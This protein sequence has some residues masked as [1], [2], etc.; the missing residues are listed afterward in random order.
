ME[1]CN[2]QYL[3]KVIKMRWRKGKSFFLLLNK[4]NQI[5]QFRVIFYKNLCNI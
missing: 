3:I 5:Q 4:K 2:Q 1:N